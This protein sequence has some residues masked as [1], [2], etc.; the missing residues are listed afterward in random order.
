MKRPLLFFLLLISNVPPVARATSWKVLPKTY[1]EYSGP[2]GCVVEADGTPHLIALERRAFAYHELR[3]AAEGASELK[4]PPPRWIHVYQS[5]EGWKQESLPDES[6]DE[7]GEHYT[8]VTSEGGTEVFLGQLTSEGALKAMRWDGGVWREFGY[9]ELPSFLI[10]DGQSEEEIRWQLAGLSSKDGVWFSVIESTTGAFALFHARGAELL[11]GPEWKAENGGLAK[12]SPDH[13]TLEL[14]A[15]NKSEIPGFVLERRFLHMESRPVLRGEFDGSEWCIRKLETI[16]ESRRDRKVS[17]IWD[18]RLFVASLGI[19]EGLGYLFPGNGDGEWHEQILD[20]SAWSN[21]DLEF[22]SEG[23]PWILYG[24]NIGG[25][26]EFPLAI[27]RCDEVTWIFEDVAPSAVWSDLVFAPDGSP[28]VAYSD[29]DAMYVARREKGRWIRELAV[30][31]GGEGG[32]V[33]AMRFS[34]EGTLQLL[35]SGRVGNFLFERNQG[36][37]SRTLIS[38]Q[39]EGGVFL[40]ESWKDNAAAAPL[41]LAFWE[42][43]AGNWRWTRSFVSPEGVVNQPLALATAEPR[44]WHFLDFESAVTLDSLTFYLNESWDREDFLSS[45]RPVTLHPPGLES[46]GGS[47]LISAAGGSARP[48]AFF[49]TSIEGNSSAKRFWVASANDGDPTRVVYRS[50]PPPLRYLE[51][52]IDVPIRTAAIAPFGYEGWKLL[53]GGDD[54]SVHLLRQ[55]DIDQPLESERLSVIPRVEEFS[56]IEAD[57]RGGFLAVSSVDNSGRKALSYHYRLDEHW[58]DESVASFYSFQVN[59]TSVVAK[60]GT[61]HVAFFDEG[62]GASVVATRSPEGQWALEDLTFK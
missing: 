61:L 21:C 17:A 37:W 5:R 59:P 10:G 58:V 19:S 53:Q 15:S 18:G 13:F 49:Q 27:A 33:S 29:L 30:G 41:E 4:P 47:R 25:I 35:V 39:G 44:R 43:E 45:T 11:P 28:M 2:Y 52:E 34:S 46:V 36:G 22:D 23:R 57:P 26:R 56:W 12:G 16:S 54:G 1:A 42:L 20:R 50:G 48:L 60:D 9:F 55:K 32:P 51:V 7:Q 6:P 24:A 38:P 40:D 31:G 3:A 62:R 14:F 8:L